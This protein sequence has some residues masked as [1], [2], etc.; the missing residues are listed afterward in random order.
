[1][2]R[3]GH[4]HVRLCSVIWHCDEQANCNGNERRHT[5]RHATQEIDGCWAAAG[6]EDSCWQGTRSGPGVLSHTYHRD[7]TRPKAELEQPCGCERYGAMDGVGNWSANR[8]GSVGRTC[9]ADVDAHPLA[10]SKEIIG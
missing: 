4:F 2:V 7:R 9:F 3:L 6:V 1:M 10:T 8:S 5:E